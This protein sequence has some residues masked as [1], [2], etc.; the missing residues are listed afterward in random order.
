M[1]PTTLQSESYKEIFKVEIFHGRNIN[2]EKNSK[3]QMGFE[4]TTLKEGCGFKLH[5]ELGIFFP[6]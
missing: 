1:Q 6:S 3:F 4:P 5:L 2:L